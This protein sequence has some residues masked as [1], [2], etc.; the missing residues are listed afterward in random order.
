EPI[1][2]RPYDPAVRR[3][4]RVESDLAYHPAVFLRDLIH[5]RGGRAE[6]GRVEAHFLADTLSRAHDFPHSLGSMHG[7]QIHVVLRV[8][9][10]L[11]PAG[12][13]VADVVPAHP[14]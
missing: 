13:Q 1:T 5:A 2:A 6:K 11:E 4:T 8:R 9:A 3:Q 14:P 12:S 7:A 10:D